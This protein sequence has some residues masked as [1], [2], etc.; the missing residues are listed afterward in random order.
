MSKVQLSQDVAEV[1]L[2]VCRNY[3]RI[4]QGEFENPTC[5][6]S[7]LLKKALNE[8]ESQLPAERA[9]EIKAFA[10][11]QQLAVVDL[12]DLNLDDKA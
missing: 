4:Q 10:D 7:V 12:E 6:E 9:A 1:F 11:S 5:E 2:G 8:V 3:F